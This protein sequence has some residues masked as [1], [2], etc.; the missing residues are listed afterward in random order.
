ILIPFMKREF[1]LNLLFLLAINLLVKPIYI[2]GV[3][4]GFQNAV[5]KDEYG[6]FAALLSFSYILQTINDFGIQNFNNRNISQHPKLIYRFFPNI[7]TLKIGLSVL[8]MILTLSIGLLLGYT[9]FS[10][11]LLIWL[12]GNQIL[13]TMILYFRS[14]ISGLQYYRWDSF[15]S[16][17]DRILMLIIGCYLLMVP[18]KQYGVQIEWLVYAQTV[19]YALT[20]LIAILVLMPRMGKIKF[21]LNLALMMVLLKRSFPYA[22]LIFLMSMYTRVDQV[23]LFRLLPDGASE[24]GIYA[25]AYR[26]LDA[27]NMIGFLFAGLLLPMF[28]FMLGQKQEIGAL[29]KTGFSAV[30]ILSLGVAF[31]CFFFRGPI[32][33]LLYDQATE[34]WSAV[35][36]VLIFSFIAV[37]GSY[38]FGTLLTADGQLKVL[39]YISFGGLVVNVALNFVMIL[40]FKALGAAWVTTI[41]QSFVFSAQIWWCYQNYELGIDLKFWLRVLA[42]GCLLASAGWF[43]QHIDMDLLGGTLLFMVA[44]GTAALGTGL[45]D[46]QQ[47]FNQ[48]LRKQEA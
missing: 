30:L 42:Y 16:S 24:V 18:G 39:N 8:Y 21:R 35:L 6:I 34:Y 2:F 43:I 26:L 23:M 13:V 7:I 41:T 5:G 45:L 38:I 46:I 31:Y 11:H 14:N 1:L 32:M 9:G 22:L 20:L 10:F 25:A 4:L 37:S 27:S 40:K 12:A 19:S 29:V 28:A 48:F 3:D 15:L 17:L 36:G 47:L 44:G 33:N